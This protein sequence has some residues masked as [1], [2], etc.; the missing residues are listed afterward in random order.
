MLRYSLLKVFGLLVVLVILLKWSF[1]FQEKK[2]IRK[3]IREINKEKGYEDPFID[4]IY[5]DFLVISGFTLSNQSVNI[6][7][8]KFPFILDWMSM[9]DKDTD[10]DLFSDLSGMAI[11]MDDDSKI[12]IYI[13]YDDWNDLTRY[14]KRKLL[15]HELLHDCYNLE[16]VNDQCD[17]MA[18]NI[19]YCSNVDLN[20]SLKKIIINRCRI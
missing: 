20:Q 8:A 17:I 16:H 18:P 13:D 14:E 15:Y 19:N 5:N 6:K 1:S 9:Y 10:L 11:G 4:K 3:F 7:L 2:Q 12:E